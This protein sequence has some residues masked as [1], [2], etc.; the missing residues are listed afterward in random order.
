MVWHPTSS[1]HDFGAGLPRFP[2]GVQQHPQEF[3]SKPPASPSSSQSFG[4]RFG[5]GKH[6]ASEKGGLDSSDFFASPRNPDDEEHERITVPQPSSP[7]PLPPPSSPVPGII[8]ANRKVAKERFGF[9]GK[10]SPETRDSSD[11]FS[12]TT[13]GDA[14]KGVATHAEDELYKA[15]ESGLRRLTTDDSDDDVSAPATDDEVPRPFP[16]SVYHE[17]SEEEEEMINPPPPPLTP[18][19]AEALAVFEFHDPDGSGGPG[20]NVAAQADAAWSLWKLATINN[21]RRGRHDGDDHEEQQGG[22]S[23]QQAKNNDVVAQDVL[24]VSK[25]KQSSDNVTGEIDESVG[26]RSTGCT[27]M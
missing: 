18:E 12:T 17:E 9:G 24:N 4:S 1:A 22:A 13:G 16:H 14:G 10:A 8:L 2:F 26:L 3:S 25:E 20:S 19:E 15:V 5:F 21:K 23:E 11:F 7:R 6:H 27:P